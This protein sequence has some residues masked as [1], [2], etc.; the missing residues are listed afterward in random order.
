MTKRQEGALGEPGSFWVPNSIDPV[1]QTRS[2]ARSA[3]YDPVKNRTNLHVLTGHYVRKLVL[4]GLT[5]EGVEIVSR[6]DNL[7]SLAFAYQEVILS[8]GTVHTPHILQLSGIGPSEVLKAAGIEVLLDV[9][10]IGYVK[11]SSCFSDGGIDMSQCKLPGSSGCLH[12]I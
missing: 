4:S 2:S 8:A 3:Y 9:P 10:G 6:A 12:Y 5:I 7:T 11:L 1:Y